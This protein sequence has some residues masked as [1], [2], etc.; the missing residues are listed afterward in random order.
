MLNV[1]LTIDAEVWPLT[2]DWRQV[3]LRRDI[4]RDMHGI[5]EQG[6]YGLRY[7]LELLNHHSLKAVFFVEPFFAAAAGMH[8]LKQIVDDIRS[9]G[10]EIQLH[11]HSEWL[12]MIHNTI[13]PNK[14]GSHLTDFSEDEQ[15]TLIADGLEKLRDCGVE[16]I[17][18][19][20]AGSFGA[21][22]ATLKALAR[23]GIT[24]DS[25]YNPAYLHTKCKLNGCGAIF[26]PRQLAGVWEF[27]VTVFSNWA[28]RPRPAQIT[29]VS[30]NEMRAAL[31]QA[32][33]RKWHSF[34]IVS[35]TFEFLKRRRR[36]LDLPQVD[37]I[38]VRRFE[39][40]CQFLAA[41]RD[42]FRTVGF[43]DIDVRQIPG[44]QPERTLHSAPLH[45][46][47]RLVEQAIRR[48]Y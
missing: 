18:A 3:G 32:A 19:F 6:D 27:P 15:T 16:N 1:L 45:T 48:V 46:G 37:P 23:N 28:G 40:L 26:Q 21:N 12:A 39:R 41:N 33:R 42:T 14:T 24:F 11:L 31:L 8:V 29:A 9:A 47:W 36:H 17:C 30:F 43:S 35:H 5:V 38:S 13:L 25:S 20:R 2:N 7:Q 34:T 4:D 44:K 10:Q 22:F